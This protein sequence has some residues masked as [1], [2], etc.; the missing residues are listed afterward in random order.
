M[1]INK[2]KTVDKETLYHLLMAGYTLA[3]M[4]EILGMTE[5]KV[6]QNLAAHRLPT[7]SALRGPRRG[8]RR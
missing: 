1:P 3:E 8:G 5:Q 4:A 2:R 6:R 7:P